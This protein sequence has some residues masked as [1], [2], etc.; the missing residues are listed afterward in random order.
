MTK[1]TKINACTAPALLLLASLMFNLAL[2][3]IDR[4][5]V[6]RNLEEERTRLRLL[7]TAREL[8][9]NRR[10]LAPNR[11][12]SADS[13]GRRRALESSM[14]FGRA[15]ESSMN[16]GRA[17]ESSMNF[18]RALES[19]MNFGRALESSMNFGR[20]LEASKERRLRERVLSS[21]ARR[22]LLLE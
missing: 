21:T 1:R 12:L 2:T 3:D 20:A 8:A 4:V 22:R 17:L 7:P 13:P 9:T 18:G 10:L 16:F 14:N 15:L 11:A 5:V 6:D 19:S